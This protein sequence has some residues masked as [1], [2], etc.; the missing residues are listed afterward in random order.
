MKIKDIMSMNVISIDK[1]ET[2]YDCAEKMKEHN[3]GF[4]V[5]SDQKKV[6]GILS[7]RDIV[8]NYLA[9]KDTSKLDKYI[10][11]SII[12]VNIND[13]IEIACQKMK[14]YK[15]K[16]L[17]VTEDNKIKGIISISDLYNKID[18]QVLI[19]TI[20]EIFKNNKEIPF[21]ETEIKDFY[22]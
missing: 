20:K 19:E 22:L 13:D 12:S 11:R 3:I 17:V 16:R 14:T 5:I 21:I 2:I 9:N 7:D 8:I 1:S 18:E 10:N 4:I 15:I 6:I